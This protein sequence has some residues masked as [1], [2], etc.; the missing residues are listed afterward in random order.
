MFTER[1]QQAT[2]RRD[3]RLELSQRALPRKDVQVRERYGAAQRIARVAVPVEEGLELL[4]TTEERPVNALGGQRSGQ[5]QQ[6]ARQR[7]TDRQEHRIHAL[8]I[9][10]EHP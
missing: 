8:G 9:A 10:S 7:L 5:A 4:V 1:A 3:L 2:Q 6:A